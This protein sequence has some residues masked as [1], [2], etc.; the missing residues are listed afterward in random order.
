MVKESLE[1]DVVSQSE[2]YNSMVKAFQQMA[3]EAFGDN[4]E[5]IYRNGDTPSEEDVDPSLHEGEDVQQLLKWSIPLPHQPDAA[6]RLVRIQ[7]TPAETVGDSTAQVPGTT[8]E[9]HAIISRTPAGTSAGSK[10][11]PT[12]TSSSLQ[13]RNSI[14]K[15][16]PIPANSSRQSGNPIGWTPTFSRHDYSRSIRDD[17][18]E[19]VWRGKGRM[20]RKALLQL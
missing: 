3:T 16:S 8:S 6:V 15:E 17:G 5:A 1:E 10:E 13:T 4:F 18:Q 11:S 19:A 2:L 14:S 7:D 9:N 12:P 20:K